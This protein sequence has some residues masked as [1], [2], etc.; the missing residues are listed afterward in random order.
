VSSIIRFFIAP[1]DAAAARMPLSGPAREPETLEYG[2]FDPVGMLDDWEAAFLARDAGEIAE[3]GRPA[4][5]GGARVVPVA[6]AAILIAVSP[7]LTADLAEADESRLAEVRAHWVQL[8]SLD[9]RELHPVLA[10]EL[11]T[12]IAELA[13]RAN[14]HGHGM[15]C[16]WY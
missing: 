13:A 9:G 14:E 4:I 5:G 1:D 15:Y 7:D 11:L 3:G 2:N 6:G 10:V 8:E 16:W 12:E